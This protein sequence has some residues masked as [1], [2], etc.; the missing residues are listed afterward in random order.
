MR[1]TETDSGRAETRTSLNGIV[2]ALERELR[3]SVSKRELARHLLHE[4]GGVQQI[5][6]MIKDQYDASPQGS[7]MRVA[8]AKLVLET[9]LGMQGGESPL[10]SNLTREQLLNIIA[11]A[12]KASRQRTRKAH[13][14]EDAEAP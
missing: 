2:A 7:S 13:E 11:Y 4:F 8:I 6:R 9:V 5:A 10:L 3:G 1:D 12:T 14:G